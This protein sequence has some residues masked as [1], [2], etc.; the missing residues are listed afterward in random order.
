[1][2]LLRLALLGVIALLLVSVVV[3]ILTGTTGVFEKLVLAVLGALLVFAAARV[4]HMEARPRRDRA[5]VS[6]ARGPETAAGRR[7]G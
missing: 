5:G 6:L 1:V 3:G 2:R 7:R 4:R